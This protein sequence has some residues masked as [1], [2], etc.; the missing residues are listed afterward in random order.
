MM[1]YNAFTSRYNFWGKWRA[2]GKPP[3]DVDDDDLDSNEVP[4]DASLYFG[5]GTI[6][7]TAELNLL[8]HVQDI[9]CEYVRAEDV[10]GYTGSAK[11][12]AI[13]LHS[14]KYYDN[15]PDCNEYVIR[16]DWEIAE[17]DCKEKELYIADNKRCYD[18]FFKKIASCFTNFSML[19]IHAEAFAQFYEEAPELAADPNV[20]LAIIYW[21]SKFSSTMFDGKC[22]LSNLVLRNCIGLVPNDNPQ[23]ADGVSFEDFMKSYRI[24]RAI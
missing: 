6:I 16:S 8:A 19:T 22:I 2:N 18:G 24:K 7:T 17:F 12:Y 15:L 9:T 20:T 5:D 3:V 1:K 13:R 11:I 4:S 10:Y 21:T 23:F 14:P